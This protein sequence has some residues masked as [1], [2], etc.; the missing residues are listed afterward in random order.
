VLGTDGAATAEQ[1][2]RREAIL[3]AAAELF[4]AGQGT[5]AVRVDEI[6]AR[7]GVSKATLYRYFPSKAA[8]VEAVAA[9]HGQDVSSWQAPDRREQ[10]LDAAM[11]LIPQYGVR[12]TTM[13]QIAEAAGISA[14]A[15]YWHFASKE[16]LAKA[17]VDRCS[18]LP[19]VRHVLARGAEGDPAEDLRALA[20]LMLHVLAERLAVIQAAMLESATN[21]SFATHVLQNVALPIW[22]TI[23][24]YFQAHVAA[25]RLRAAPPLPRVFSFAGP[26]LAFTLGRRALGVVFPID[27]EQ[28]VDTLVDTFLHGAA[29]PRYRE[30][31]QRRGLARG[32]SAAHH[33]GAGGQGK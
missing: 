5:Q 2:A 16:A 22:M 1:G 28:L 32:T 10:I 26:I 27:P 33:R 15:I 6:A 14:P 18:P 24:N 7:A 11:R 25:G 19:E 30:K 8:I 31:L 21:P 13:E 9:E 23:G 17:L 4:A 20:R 29:T 3:R 12:A